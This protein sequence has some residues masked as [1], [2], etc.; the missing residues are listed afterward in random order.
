[1]THADA[2]TVRELSPR[3]HG[4]VSIVALRGRGALERAR[5]AAA[6]PN[7][8][9][10]DVRVVAWRTASGV[11]DRALC[12]V[13]SA[14]EVE[15]H[16]HGNPVLVDALL[17]EFEPT[18]GEPERR[19][20]TERQAT[21]PDAGGASLEARALAGLA[22]STTDSAARILLDQVGGA[23]RRELEAQAVA[24]DRPRLRALI[25]RSRTARRA[26]EP[27][28]VVLAGPVNAGKSTLFNA[29]L[30][31]RRAIVSARPGT[32]RDVLRAHASFGAYPIELFDVAGTRA[33][34]G[35]A[36]DAELERAGQA[37][38]LELASR[39]DWIVWLAPLGEPVPHELGA[40]AT[41]FLSRADVAPP[42]LASSRTRRL[43]VFADPARAVAAIHAAFRARFSLP[44]EPW[45]PGAA[46]LF[47]A[48]AFACATSAECEL[49]DP[50]ARRVIARALAV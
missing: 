49:D 24:L 36:P 32:T 12:V 18:G 1:M 48:A 3:G 29:L 28:R 37:L 22:R 40:R 11:L 45:T 15:L 8:A 39:A 27:S 25:E 13:I 31:E 50:S 41:E 46:V 5:S 33:V 21:A 2:L 47:D 35:S 26:L 7:L 30:G 6:R 38:A 10:G 34:A 9:P 16:L 20:N 42:E 23:L 43:S 14:D 19:A 4:A 44:E 17:A